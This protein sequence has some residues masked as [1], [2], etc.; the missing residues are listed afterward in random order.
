MQ[1]F[2]RLLVPAP[3]GAGNARDDFVNAT[4]GRK[5]LVSAALEEKA[6]WKR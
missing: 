2:L 5:N 4:K 3:P 1:S 6:I